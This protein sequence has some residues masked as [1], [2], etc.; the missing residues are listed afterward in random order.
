MFLSKS[1]FNCEST[2]QQHIIQSFS[3]K[4]VFIEDKQI[5][6]ISFNV[7]VKKLFSIFKGTNKQHILKYFIQKVVFIV[8]EQKTIFHSIFQTKKLF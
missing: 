1:C 6:N 7:S 5:N 2:N 3:Q 8:D 4:V